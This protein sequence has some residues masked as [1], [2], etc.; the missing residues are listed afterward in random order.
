MLEWNDAGSEDRTP[1]SCCFRIYKG[2]RRQTHVVKTFHQIIEWK[3]RKRL[4][5]RLILRILAKA[6]P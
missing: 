5:L 1:C 4:F 2:E 6:V 3:K